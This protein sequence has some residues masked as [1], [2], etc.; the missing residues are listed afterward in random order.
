MADIKNVIFDIGNVVIRWEPYAALKIFYP[1][2][3]AMNVHLV[4]IGFFDWNIEQDRGRSLEEGLDHAR[5][6]TKHADIFEAYVNGLDKS[7]GHQIPGTSGIIRKLSDKRV[8]MYGLSNI[9]EEA[10]AIVVETAPELRLFSHTTISA[11]VKMVKPKP[12]I[13]EYCLQKNGLQPSE[14]LFIDDS[15]E[16]CQTALGLGLQTHHFQNADSLAKHLQDIS[17]L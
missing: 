2:A 10:Y 3:A 16:N 14:T 13:F 8:P 4:E 5:L 12:E 9:T 7:H 15:E 6:H 1:D 17:L 11:R